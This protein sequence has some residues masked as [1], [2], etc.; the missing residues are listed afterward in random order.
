MRFLSFLVGTVIL[1]A[2][3]VVVLAGGSWWLLGRGMGGVAFAEAEG[4]GPGHCWGGGDQTREVPATVEEAKAAFEGYL[5]KQ[6]YSGLEVVEVMEFSRNFYAI[7]RESETGIG[8]M[9][10]LMDR[11]TGVVG[12]EY[13]PNMMWNAKY[14]MHRWR[15]S[16]EAGVS[17]AEAAEIAREWLVANLPGATVEDEVDAFYGYY[18]LH[19]ERD[20]QIEGML[21]VHAETGQ[22]WYHSWHGDFIAMLDEDH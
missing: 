2:L 20:G 17:A 14:G 22:V 6:G 16:D 21:S 15:W 8:A 1:V 13:G 18:T 10:L 3:V 7:A 9:E 19:T 11:D 5:N 12:P 4:W